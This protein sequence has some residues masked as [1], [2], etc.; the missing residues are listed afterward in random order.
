MASR[1]EQTIEKSCKLSS[2]CNFLENGSSFFVSKTGSENLILLSG[3]RPL[4]PSTCLISA[5]VRPY[6][7][8]KTYFSIAFVEPSLLSWKPSLSIHTSLYFGPIESYNFFAC[9]LVYLLNEQ[10][11]NV[12]WFRHFEHFSMFEVS[13]TTVLDL[14]YC[15]DHNRGSV[16][17]YFLETCWF[18]WLVIAANQ[19]LEWG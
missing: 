8:I 12:E 7:N 13:Y 2:T 11:V 17:M 5:E 16:M 10:K 6:K 14:F 3:S 9:R 18:S 4:F 19:W 15:D 1:I